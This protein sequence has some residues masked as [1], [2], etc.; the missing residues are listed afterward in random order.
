[1]TDRVRWGVLGPAAIAVHKVIPAMQR[2]QHCEVVA[3]ASRDAERATAAAEQMG[4]AR[5][6]GSY[7]DLLTDPDVEAVYIPLP[8]HLH[9]EWTLRAAAAGKHV[10]CEKPLALSA[11][12]A[13]E[14]V[15]G[16][17]AAGVLLM[18][19]FM[20]RL[21]P[22]W[23]RVRDLVTSG[24]IGELEAIQVF[25][26]YHNV[27]PANIRNIA[28]YGG[29]ALMD[30]GCY[31]INVARWM[32]DAEPTA[33][34]AAVRIDP[35]FGTDAVTSAVLDFGGRH[36]T[37]TC[38]TQ[39]EPDQRVHL[40]GSTGRLLVEIPFNIP[41]DLPTRIIHASGGDPPVAPGIDVIEVPAAD[42]YTAQ[43]DAFSAAIRDGSAVP[44]PPQDA[45]ANMA[46]ID[47]ILE[48][49]SGPST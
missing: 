39:T 20:Y 37:F 31:A 9:A 38:S 24:T 32:F 3:I 13:A 45:V 12:Q 33:V 25:F 1:M 14:M 16:C 44:I 48:G 36:A 28:E 7:D 30:V 4:I 17:R 15:E 42:P 8:N 49:S 6:H 27:D 22:L 19:A 18:E 35:R 2:S 43:C 23:L 29:G 5:H 46:V 40:I 41:P 47:H 11:A 34:S 26:A 10:L 21:H